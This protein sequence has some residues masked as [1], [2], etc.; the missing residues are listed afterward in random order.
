MERVSNLLGK[1]NLCHLCMRVRVL[2]ETLF[3]ILPHPPSYLLRKESL[4]CFTTTN[5]DK[6][7][8]PS[9]FTSPSSPSL[10]FGSPLP[11]QKEPKRRRT[12]GSEI[13]ALHRVSS[14]VESVLCV[15][16]YPVWFEFV[17]I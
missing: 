7:S 13:V 2:S 3:L 6:Y 1:T 9:P 16:V 17:V 15:S 4:P 10:T 14:K 12:Y 8:N 5:L 11:S